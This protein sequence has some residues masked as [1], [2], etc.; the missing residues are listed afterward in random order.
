V[1]RPGSFLRH[2]QAFSSIPLSLGRSSCRYYASIASP[3]LC[4]HVPNLLIRTRT[5]QAIGTCLTY[6]SGVILYPTCPLASHTIKVPQDRRYS[7]TCSV[8]EKLER[9]SILD[10]L[11]STLALMWC[12]CVRSVADQ[13]SS[14]VYIRRQWILISQLPQVHRICVS[15]TA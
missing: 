4:D 12:H 9:S 6:L 7:L 13:Y 11:S 8:C 2:C 14:T 15:R 1:I 3:D 5:T 10:R